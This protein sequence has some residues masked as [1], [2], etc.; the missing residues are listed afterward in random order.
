MAQGDSLIEGQADTLGDEASERDGRGTDGG[1]G[2]TA[3][4]ATSSPSYGSLV[5]SLVFI[6]II[7]GCLAVFSPNGASSH[8]DQSEVGGEAE[9]EGSGFDDSEGSNTSYDHDYDS[10]ASSSYSYDS[11][12]YDPDDS[13]GHSRSVD[14]D[15]TLGVELDDG[16]TVYQDGSGNYYYVNP[17]G[18]IEATDGWGNVG[19][20]TDQDGE[21]DYYSTDSGDTWHE[22]DY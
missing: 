1:D 14:D 7:V 6:A 11:D 12:S 19:V 16:S 3:N 2:S 20:D 5:A 17:D 21:F 8:S 9:Y 22:W 18:S 15:S 13:S 10:D 4:K